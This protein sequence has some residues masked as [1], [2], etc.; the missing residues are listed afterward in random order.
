LVEQIT[1]LDS[2][3]NS[4]WY[5]TLPADDNGFEKVLTL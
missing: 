4:L 5:R 1:G 2:I 3:F